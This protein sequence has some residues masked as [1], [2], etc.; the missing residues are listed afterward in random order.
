VLNLGS[1]E[2]IN[3]ATSREELVNLTKQSKHIKTTQPNLNTKPKMSISNTGMTSFYPTIQ[4]ADP[5]L[6]SLADYPMDVV[7]LIIEEI[8]QPRQIINIEISG[9]EPLNDGVSEWDGS[10]SRQTQV[11]IQSTP[12]NA[13]TGVNRLFRYM[14]RQSR[15]T[16]WGT[17][18]FWS[19]PY[20]VNLSRDIFHVRVKRVVHPSEWDRLGN[21]HLDYLAGALS[22]IQHMAVNLFRIVNPENQWCL[23]YLR[24]LNPLT[25]QIMILV[26]IGGVERDHR[27][28]GGLRLSPMLRPVEGRTAQ[29]GAIWRDLKRR[30]MR[31]MQ[32]GRRTCLRIATPEQRQL[33]EQT[34][35]APVQEL[36][37]Y[38]VDPRRLARPIP[39]S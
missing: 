17:H 39:P 23:A 37:A 8:F 4:V 6:P 3:M 20:Y 27:S 13:L 38:M 1:H 35:L 12:L 32:I 31:R 9:P 33:W 10:I 25:K 2:Y 5:R 30:L 11:V 34:W 7:L 14:Y 19:R 15:P 18:L 29:V 24:H 21:P 28:G 16:P 26:P 22:G 36:E